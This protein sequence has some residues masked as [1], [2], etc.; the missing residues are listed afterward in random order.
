M[1]SEIGLVSGAL[2]A[3]GQLLESEIDLVSEALE[4]TGEFLYESIDTLSGESLA[5]F[6]H[7]SHDI[8][9]VQE[10]LLKV[11]GENIANFIYL[12]DTIPFTASIPLPRGIDV[13]PVTFLSLGYNDP[14][15]SPPP[16]FINLN[17]E[18]NS[19]G[20]YLYGVRDITT[21]GFYIDFSDIISE[22]NNFLDIIIYKN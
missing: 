1:E 3:T 16:V 8:D 18:S 17:Y 14:L 11:S 6:A 12:E 20:F 21:T 9:L 7:M 13:L 5:G 2:D 19:L 4:S 22:Q 10:E 15:L